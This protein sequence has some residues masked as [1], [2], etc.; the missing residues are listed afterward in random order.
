MKNY[1]MLIGIISLFLVAACAQQEP[2]SQDSVVGQGTP[3]G[4]AGSS[5]AVPA[6]GNGD[7]EE[8]I[9][10]EGEGISLPPEEGSLVHDVEPEVVEID[11]TAKQWEFDPETITVKE[12]QKV[13]LNIK[14]IDVAHGFALPDF[15]VNAN[16]APG[17]TVDVKF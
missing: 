17:K 8:M 13:K 16:L 12:G 10:N 14:S 2:K 5:M 7:V 9:V 3:V 15:G 1:L 4:D 11:M 6:P